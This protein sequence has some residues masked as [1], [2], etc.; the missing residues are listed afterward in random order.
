MKAPENRAETPQGDPQ[1][2][3]AEAPPL[4]P[5]SCQGWPV[6]KEMADAIYVRLP[7]ELQRPTGGCSCTY[8]VTHPDEIPMW[9][10]LGIP[11]LSTRSKVSAITWT[12]HAPEWGRER[13]KD[14]P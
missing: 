9:D 4:P 6:I 14:R 2:I 5:I 7:K 11:R 3:T 10:T 12:L 1:G 13:R 8:C